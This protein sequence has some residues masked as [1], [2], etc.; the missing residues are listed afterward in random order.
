MPELVVDAAKI[1][2]AAH[3]AI[4]LTITTY[5]LPHEIEIYMEQVLEVFL[6]EIGQKKLKDYLVYSLRELAVNAKKANTKRVFFQECS[7]D[8]NDGKEY[9]EGMK[10]F[11]QQTLENIN[12]YLGLQKEAGL[13]IKLM[14]QAKGS[15]IILEVRNNSEINK[16][17]YVRIHDKLARARS[18]DSLEEVM[19]QVVDPTE[20]AGLGL[21]ILILMLKK[22]GLDEDCFDIWAEG[23]ETVAR[24]TI[25]V[26]S[27]KIESLSLLSDEVVRN[28]SRLPQFPENVAEVQRL[29]VD[30]R[31]QMVDIARKIAM[32]PAMTGELLRMVNSAQYML[33]KK[34]DNI[35]EAVKLVGLRGIKNLL[36]SYGTQK[37]L[38]GDDSQEKRELWQ[39]SYR[40]A[41]YA[42]NLSRNFK[43]QNKALLDDVYVG[44]MLHDMGKI[45]FSTVHPELL[46]HIE[47]FC[48]RKNITSQV[49]EQLSAGMHHAEIGARIAEKWEFPESLVTS[50]RFHHEPALSQD[51]KDVVNA[52]YLANAMT[53]FE[54]GE[55]SFDQIDRAALTDFG[56]ATEGQLQKIVAQFDAGFKLESAAQ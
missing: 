26:A 12:H 34:V 50:I 53:E 5:T 35:P 37:V 4:P 24:I 27:A 29:I 51:H 9:E 45:V 13:Y 6:S 11:K 30:P 21:V 31:S 7:L 55:M 1:K 36:Y 46:K 25:P 41:F 2:K 10:G 15:S 3:N 16:M 54:L 48:V 33:S 40:T 28:I 42:Y 38:G 19:G 44:G 8:I 32:D 56:I 52:V 43:P 17:E 23:G 14:F 47:E 39:H 20:G 22:I 18:Y 49:F